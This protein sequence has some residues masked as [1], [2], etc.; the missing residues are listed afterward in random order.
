[1]RGGV[2]TQGKQL[3]CKHVAAAHSKH[4]S[5]GRRRSA[6]TPEKI[7][8][9]NPSPPSHALQCFRILLPYPTT[10]PTRRQA[11]S[12]KTA[13][14]INIVAVHVI[15]VLHQHPGPLVDF[16]LPIFLPAPPCL[17]F[18]IE[19]RHSEIILEVAP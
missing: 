16:H 19:E 8:V 7:P 2:A 5:T 18:R 4:P 13:V 11:T 12:I 10:F 9:I 15:P 17:I 3:A 14:I 1:M 6:G